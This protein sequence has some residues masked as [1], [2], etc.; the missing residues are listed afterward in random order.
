MYEL[1]GIIFEPALTWLHIQGEA[2]DMGIGWSGIL[3]IADAD[4]AKHALGAPR[5]GETNTELHAVG[6]TYGV[7][8]LLSDA[9]HWSSTGH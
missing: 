2:V 5:S 4:G 7:Q 1:F 6:A 3:T 8:Q 9:P